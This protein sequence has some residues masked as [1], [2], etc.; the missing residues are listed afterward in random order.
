MLRNAQPMLS[1]Q[2][3]TPMPPVAAVVEGVE[4]AEMVVGDV[5]VVDAVVMMLQLELVAVVSTI[6][7]V[8][9]V[10]ADAVDVV[11]D[12][13]ATMSEKVDVDVDMVVTTVDVGVD[14]GLVADGDRVDVVGR[15]GTD[16]NTVIPTMMATHVTQ[17]VED[18][19]DVQVGPQVEAVVAD[20]V[21]HVAAVAVAV[22]DRTKSALAFPNLPRGSAP[23]LSGGGS[24]LCPPGPDS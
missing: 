9:T 1:E 14:E 6:V 3:P 21:P 22:T 15:T 16:A 18:M 11:V 13:E 4:V 8:V 24:S 2:Q 10:D 17:D 5:V 7:N 23:E 19:A 20:G 12:V